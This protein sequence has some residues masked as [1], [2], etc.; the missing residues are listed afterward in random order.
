[1]ID[2]NDNNIYTING[3]GNILT[4]LNLTGLTNNLGVNMLSYG[5]FT[6]YQY[7]RKYASI[8][9]QLSWK[10]KL[11]TPNGKNPHP[12]V[13]I[14][15]LPYDINNLTPGWHHFSLSFD[16][17][18]GTIKAYLDSV[19]QGDTVTFAP[20]KYQLYYTYRTSLLL[21]CE[22]IQNTTLNDIID[23]DDGYKFVGQV[24][25]LRLYNKSLTKGEIE[26]LYFS[27][28]YAAD[29]RSLLWNM[30]VGERN[31]IEQ[32][33]HWYKMQLPGS[34]S[35]YYNINI[36]NLNIPDQVKEVI[37]NSIK[38]NLNKIAPANTS[39]YKINWK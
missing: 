20:H 10:L 12:S 7:L 39:L 11:A 27:S 34:K 30:S 6:G 38:N 5:D 33:K 18:N 23:I 37:E 32:I 24:A 9:R 1:L 26:Q 17:I 16:G 28:K 35:K 8:N 36:H 21:G 15:I 3:S 19:Q 4:K 25:E 22:T 14:K 29:D 31:Y 2:L 13:N